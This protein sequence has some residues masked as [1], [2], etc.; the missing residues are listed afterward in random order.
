M[1]LD[2]ITQPLWLLF[3]WLTKSVLH[4][5]Q[6]NQRLALFLDLSTAFDTIDHNYTTV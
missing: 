3:K 6:T 2:Q 5:K 1:V 4:L